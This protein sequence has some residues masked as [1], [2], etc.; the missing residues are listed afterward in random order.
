MVSVEEAKRSVVLMFVGIV[1]IMIWLP[2][3]VKTEINN[4]S[5]RIELKNVEEAIK[6]V[7][8]KFKE[9]LLKSQVQ[10]SIS[11]EG[12]TTTTTSVITTTGV[13]VEEAERNSNFNIPEFAK[14]GYPSNKTGMKKIASTDN[15]FVKKTIQKLI[16]KVDPKTKKSYY[17]QLNSPEINYYGH[18]EINVEFDS[19]VAEIKDYLKINS[20]TELLSLLNHLATENTNL[21]NDV[22]GVDGN[23]DI[24]IIHRYY[25]IPKDFIVTDITE[26]LEERKDNDFGSEL[27]FKLYHLEPGTKDE[28]IEMIRK[29]RQSSNTIQKWLG[30]LLTFLLL[31]GGLQMLIEPIRVIIEGSSTII[32][33]TNIKIN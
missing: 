10:V 15:I 11:T 33:N 7:K 1:C 22:I 12:F 9:G 24:K 29:R 23:P 5:N 27:E 18:N 4:K 13:S 26:L 25:T 3:I 31:A 14:T 20:E 32:R 30:R 28:V 6:K 2:T 17:K 8:D 16:K 21:R 19:T